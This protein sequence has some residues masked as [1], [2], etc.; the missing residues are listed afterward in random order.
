M[1][2]NTQEEELSRKSRNLFE[3]NRYLQIREMLADDRTQPYIAVK[4]GFKNASSIQNILNRFDGL[5]ELINSEVNQTLDRL[6]NEPGL[7][8]DGEIFIP[9]SAIDKERRK[10]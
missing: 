7:N 3:W 8:C 6:K 5:E 1:S 2:T 10:V 9:L 4:L